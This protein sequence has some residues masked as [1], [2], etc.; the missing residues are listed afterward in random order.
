LWQ[1]GRSFSKNKIK[2][3]SVIYD[4]DSFIEEDIGMTVKEIKKL[5]KERGINGSKMLKA[6]LIRAIQIQ[7]GNT[8]CF[9]TGIVPC[10][11]AG[12]CWWGDCQKD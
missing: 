5:A 2:G 9:Q 6:D 12:C 7:E 4:S 3:K 8:P 11:Q 10:P 1:P